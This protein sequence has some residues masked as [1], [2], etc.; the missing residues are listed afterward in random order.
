MC[1]IVACL[2]ND[3]AAPVLLECVRRLEYRGYDS[4]GIATLSGDI[5]I[6]RVKVI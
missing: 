5:Y 6:K 2:L 4:V 3:K 1:G